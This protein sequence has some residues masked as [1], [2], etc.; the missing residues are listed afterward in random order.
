VAGSHF[1]IAGGAPGV[2]VSWQVTGVRQDPFAKANPLIPEQAK[3]DAERGYYVH[4]ELY[5]AG[6]ERGIEW[7]HQP[8]MMRQLQEVSAK[9][10]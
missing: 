3:S 8:V 4:P 9:Q 10:R 7:A 6:E 2:E 5:G 1:K